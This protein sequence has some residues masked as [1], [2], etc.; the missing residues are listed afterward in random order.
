[1]IWVIRNEF[2]YFSVLENVKYRNY[3]PIYIKLLLKYAF[4]V[5][6]IDHEGPLCAKF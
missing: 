1:M 6:K 2:G 3:I 5:V 4:F